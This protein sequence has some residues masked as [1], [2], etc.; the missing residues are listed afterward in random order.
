MSSPLS[1]HAAVAALASAFI[2]SG[3]GVPAPAIE[4]PAE[5]LSEIRRARIELYCGHDGAMHAQLRA[6]REHLRDSRCTGA[7]VAMVALANAAWLAR[8]RQ[9]DAA[10]AA[11]NRALAHLTA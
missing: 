4:V 7:D 11:L 1:R 10:G 9:F 5:V 3:A 6:A 8:R 2:Y